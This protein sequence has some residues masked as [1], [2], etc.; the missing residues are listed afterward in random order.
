MPVIGGP[1]ATRLI[2]AS[3]L[4]GQRTPIVAMTAIAMALDRTA[5]LEADTVPSSCRWAP[6]SGLGVLSKKNFQ[7]LVQR[8][9]FRL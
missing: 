8:Q 9:Y 7:F 2:R 3:E 5:C 1:E 6:E 4:V